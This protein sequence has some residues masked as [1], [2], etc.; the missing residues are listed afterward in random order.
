MWGA[1]HCYEALEPQDTHNDMNFLVMGPWFHSQV[2]RKGWSLGPLQFTGDTTLQFRHDIL[3]PF[4]N[5]YL[6]DGAPKT[7]TPPV[8][9]YNTGENRW[10]RF[11]KWPL[12]C[13]Y[14]CDNTS[15]P[16]YLE[17]GGKLSFDAPASGS[18]KYTSMSPTPPS[19][20]PLRRARFLPPMKTPGAPGWCTISASSMAVPT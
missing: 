17:A 13:N 12:S 19:P 5:Q 1:N 11:T 6:K 3:L 8:L 4:F 14:G 18:D 7:D 10:D 20:S 15:K 16:I 9:I 2:N